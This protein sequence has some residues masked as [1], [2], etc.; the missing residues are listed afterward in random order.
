MK[1]NIMLS[2]EESGNRTYRFLNNLINCGWMSG[3]IFQLSE[4]RKSFYIRQSEYASGIFLVELDKNDY[5]PQSYQEGS[6]VKIYARLAAISNFGQPSIVLK[7]LSLEQPSL[8]E[9][10]K[11]DPLANPTTANSFD[12]YKEFGLEMPF[13][14]VVNNVIVAGFLDGLVFDKD[15]KGEKK[16]DCLL[17]NLRTGPDTFLPVRIYGK[18]CQVQYDQIKKLKNRGKYLPI[19]FNCSLRS[20]AVTLSGS[21]APVIMSYL[22]SSK[23][24]FMDNASVNNYFLGK[25][26]WLHKIIESEAKPE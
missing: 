8:N 24:T 22:H 14:K 2:K 7:V 23:I 12:I 19:A 5:L 6:G 4:D 25:P 16:A 20:K 10:P 9:L 11:S 26:L 17:L 15:P 3:Y 21:E 18:R 13:G 1:G